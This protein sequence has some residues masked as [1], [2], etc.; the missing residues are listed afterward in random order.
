MLVNDLDM[1]IINTSQTYMPWTL[2]VENPSAAAVPG[3][4]VLDNVEQI[5]IPTPQA[6][7]HTL[8]ITHKNNLLSPTQN[9]ALVISGARL[10]NTG[11]EDIMENS[12]SVFPVP[13]KDVLNISGLTG[14]AEIQIIDMNGRIVKNEKLTSTTL[15]VESL[16]S[17]SYILMI[18]TDEG[19]TAKKFIKK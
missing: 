4:N 1:R 3:D 16:S 6:G 11:T 19:T 17:G 9:F 7:N 8:T 15:N 13:A 2:D 5:L 12:V 14:D 18:T 10:L